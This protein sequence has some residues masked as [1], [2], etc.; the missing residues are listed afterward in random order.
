MVPIFFFIPNL[1]GVSWICLICYKSL[2]SPAGNFLFNSQAVPCTLLFC[3]WSHHTQSTPSII[4]ESGWP[5]LDSWFTR[6]ISVSAQGGFIVQRAQG[7]CITLCK[8]NR[9]CPKMLF[10]VGMWL[11]AGTTSELF[12]FWKDQHLKTVTSTLSLGK[13]LLFAVQWKLILIRLYCP[14]SHLFKLKCSARMR[15]M[16]RLFKIQHTYK[17]T[18]SHLSLLWQTVF[19]HI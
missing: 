2:L 3:T 7:T 14:N 9:F 6:S 15:W 17:F 4:V 5:T 16:S 10:T 18:S 19:T 13:S 11:K 12:P 8:C 1:T